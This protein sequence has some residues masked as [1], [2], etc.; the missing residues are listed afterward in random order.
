MN[1]SDTVNTSIKQS[2]SI[3]VSQI[4]DKFDLKCEQNELLDLWY[5]KLIN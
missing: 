1:L 4:I 2:I 3:F 5:G